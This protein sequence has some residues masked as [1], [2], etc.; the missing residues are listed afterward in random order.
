MELIKEAHDHGYDIGGS[1]LGWSIEKSFE[2]FLKQYDLIRA[3]RFV[4]AKKIIANDKNLAKDLRAK[5]HTIREIATILG[6]KHPGSISF[7]LKP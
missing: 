4:E 2:E 3:W 1:A 7:L 5:G 6:Y